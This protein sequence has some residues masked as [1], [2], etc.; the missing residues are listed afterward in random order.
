M[1]SLLYIFLRYVG[2]RLKISY[3]NDKVS[4]ML[5]RRCEV[6]GGI[7]GMAYTSRIANQ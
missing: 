5:L 7:K 3:E 2:Q 1:G 6:R 4:V